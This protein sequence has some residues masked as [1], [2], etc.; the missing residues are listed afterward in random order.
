M[1]GDQHEGGEEL[2]V[3]TE[4]RLRILTLNRPERLNALTPEL[5]HLLHQAVA[6]AAEDAAVGAVALTGAGRAFC[7]GG[8]VRRGAFAPDGPPPT[9]EAR[10]DTLRAHS[11]TSWLL[12]R[13]PKPTVALINGAAAGAGLAIALA[14][15]LR[16]VA[17]SAVFRTAFAGVALPGDLGIS[18][19]LTRLVGPGRARELML[20]DERIGAER[21]EAL[22]LVQRVVDS[23]RLMSDGLEI[24]AKLARGPSVTYRYMKQNLAAAET[25]AIDDVLERE[26][27]NTARVAR[28]HD[29]KEATAAF[30]E[31][32]EPVFRG[33]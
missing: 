33:A 29:V 10:A 15:D 26:A 2:L 23:E 18:Y 8:D 28:T 25:G 5:H 7:A 24:A 12:A 11:Q 17:R 13:M 30:R 9:A 22:G 32:R 31:K 21:A 27:Y 16:V 1:T 3:R 6:E 4:G 20:L 14:C 19:F